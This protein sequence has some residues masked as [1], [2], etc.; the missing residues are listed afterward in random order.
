MGGVETEWRAPLVRAQLRRY[1]VRSFAP[2]RMSEKAERLL[3]VTVTLL[4]SFAFVA[5]FHFVSQ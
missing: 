1:P 5:L 2:L 3:F 4:A